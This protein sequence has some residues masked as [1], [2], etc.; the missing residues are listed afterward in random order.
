LLLAERKIVVDWLRK[1]NDTSVLP[2][3]K[4][5]PEEHDVVKQEKSERVEESGRVKTGKKLEVSGTE[6][7][8]NTETK[9]CKKIRNAKKGRL[10]V[11]NLPFKV[12]KAVSLYF[13]TSLYDLLAHFWCYSVMIT[14]TRESV[15]VCVYIHHR[16]TI[17]HN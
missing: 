10:I 9:K 15:Y 8:Q 13:Y 17:K 11:R 2:K 6:V 1:E 12:S 5:E 7:V 3:V 14:E 4:E 16:Y